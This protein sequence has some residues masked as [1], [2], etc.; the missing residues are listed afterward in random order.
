MHSHP[1]WRCARAVLVVMLGLA[2]SQAA[3]ALQ[4]R[5]RPV[6]TP[7]T[8]PVDS[9]AVEKL[10]DAEKIARLQQGI[11]EGEQVLRELRKS[12]ENPDGEYF[13]AEAAFKK[14]DADYKAKKKELTP[15]ATSTTQPTSQKARADLDDLEQRWKLAKDR[16]D[17]AIQDRKASNEAIVALE[18]TLQHDR[19]ALQK[20][21]AAPV[22]S[23]QPAIGGIP[24]EGSPPATSTQ[25][26]AGP[27]GP[28]DAPAGPSPVAG[29]PVN[30]LLPVKPPAD[31][32]SPSILIE[33]P[34]SRE[35]IEAGEQAKEKEAAAEQARQEAQTITDRLQS[36]RKAVELGRKMLET[37][38]KQ[39]GNAQQTVEAIQESIQ[40]KWR[41]GAS[42]AELDDLYSKLNAARERLATT[43]K[44]AEERSRLLRQ[45]QDDLDSL[46]SEQLAALEHVE[47]KLREAEDARKRFE[48]LSDPF[49]PL[50]VWRWLTTHGLRSLGIVLGIF[51]LLWF[52]RVSRRRLVALLARSTHRGDPEERENRAATLVAVFRSAATI[53]IIIGGMLMILTEIG[54][55]VVPLLGGAAVI[56]LAVAFGAQN[57]IKD[58]FAGFMILL[59]NQYGINDVI[60]IG[61][62]SGQVERITLRITVLRDLHGTVHFIPNGQ[63]NMVSNMTHEWSRAV[64]DVGVA[65][66]ENVDEVMRVL[67]DLGK[68]L[69]RDPAYRDAI[70]DD[71]EMLGVDSMADSA[72]VIRF[73]LKTRPAKR[74]QIRREML[75]RI[76][77]KFDE[78][79]IEIP[80]PHRTVFVRAAE[81]APERDPFQE[82]REKPSRMKPVG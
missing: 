71:P 44:A 64:F 28:A 33:K 78:L 67:V 48:E 49:H 37:A 24:P 73:V 58:Y 72:V 20:L 38:E 16:F 79:G 13:K 35:Q 8:R 77:N 34:P 4:V 59:E 54:I 10:S 23:T 2:S 66:K 57:L 1:G 12:I 80:F 18:Q 42:Q 9:T 14:L 81:E 36:L 40:K 82:V 17:L 25:P 47:D 62:V 39:S 27:A 52:M 63:I 76:K 43:K 22:S 5:P 26:A 29:I 70:L 61:A 21:L 46:Q 41:A 32:T 19:A 45:A 30:P 31:N 51:A 75:R 60:Q 50:N 11:E 6:T 15:I 69:R 55:N 53:V 65:Y 7:A 56:G 3:F 68:E 74:W